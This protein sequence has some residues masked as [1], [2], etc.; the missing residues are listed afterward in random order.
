MN[1]IVGVLNAQQ[2]KMIGAMLLGATGPVAWLLSKKLG[3][4]DADTKMWLDFIAA[5]TPIIAGVFITAGQT[6][7]AQVQAVAAMP[8]VDKVK[9]MESVPAPGLAS[10]ASALPDATVVS[11]AGDVAGTQVHVDATVA[12]PSVVAVA[13]DPARADVVPMTG[14]PVESKAS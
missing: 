6:N 8:A 3:L 12:A 9:A 5:V 1:R 14:G 13:L 7:A 10:I 4:S 2:W 11:A